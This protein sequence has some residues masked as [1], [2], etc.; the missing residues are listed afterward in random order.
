[1]LSDNAFSIMVPILER[2]LRWRTGDIRSL[3]ESNGSVAARVGE[4]AHRPDHLRET[5]AN[6][7]EAVA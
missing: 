7:G 6:E 3:F 5:G 1:M 2:V 4:G